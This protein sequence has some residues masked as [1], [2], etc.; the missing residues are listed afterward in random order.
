MNKKIDKGALLRSL[1]MIE[2]D[3]YNGFVLLVKAARNRNSVFDPD[4][5]V[6]DMAQ[7]LGIIVDCNRGGVPEFDE[8]IRDFV[9]DRS[10][11]DGSDKNPYV[12][13]RH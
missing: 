12:K 10:N 5:P 13:G 2:N 4:L 8:A 11:V 7:R 3:D 9:R 1:Q 6:W